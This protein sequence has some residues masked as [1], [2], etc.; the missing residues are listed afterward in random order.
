MSAQ[1]TPGPWVQWADTNIVIRLHTGRPQA[2]DL[3]ICEVATNTW[4]D[5][6]RHNAR[7]IAAAPE[8][9]EALRI[10][11]GNV[12]SL[13]PAGALEPYAPYREW[14]AMIDAAIAKA[15]GEHT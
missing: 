14:L 9:L 12:A 2:E 11:R 15:T 4:K 7:L 5:E 13:G 6:G 10:T 1:H 3:R 8:L